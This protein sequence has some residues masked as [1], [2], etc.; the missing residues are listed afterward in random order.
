MGGADRD[1]LLH[2]CPQV[3]TVFLLIHSNKT[4]INR[5]ANLGA[6]ALWPIARAVTPLLIMLLARHLVTFGKLDN[7]R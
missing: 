4:Q 7:S 6:G 3:Y 5:S 1:V 2:G